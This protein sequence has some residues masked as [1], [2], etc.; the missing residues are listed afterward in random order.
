MFYEKICSILIDQLINCGSL[1][2]ITKKVG[3]K[4]A[5]LVQKCKHFDVKT[6]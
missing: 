1:I 5:N 6:L 2:I 4:K 3:V